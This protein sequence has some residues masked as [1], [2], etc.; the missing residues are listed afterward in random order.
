MGE[1]ELI[2]RLQGSAVFL[3]MMHNNSSEDQNLVTKSEYYAYILS[4]SYLI[5][6][7][8]YYYFFT[9]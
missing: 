1:F 8:I 6:L 2:S 9:G 5:T 4:P 3:Q 7:G